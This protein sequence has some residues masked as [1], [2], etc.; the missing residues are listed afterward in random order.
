RPVLATAVDVLL[1]EPAATSA[2]PPPAHL[3]QHSPRGPGSHHLP[4]TNE[5][6]GSI[7]E[8]CLSPF[9]KT[10]ATPARG[11]AFSSRFMAAQPVY[12]FLPNRG[13]DSA[14]SPGTGR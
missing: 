12:R 2:V 9:A 6:T 4:L 10:L 13:K 3:H 7:S 8:W 11:I 14:C 5:G 1:P